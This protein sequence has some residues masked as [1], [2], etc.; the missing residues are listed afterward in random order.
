MA[1]LQEHPAVPTTNTYLWIKTQ[2]DFSAVMRK[3]RAIHGKLMILRYASAPGA[4]T[5]F[6]FV[7][8]KTVGGAVV[9][10]L[11][12]RRM[13]ELARVSEI[14]KPWDLIFIAKAAI[15]TS[16]FEDIKLEFN[17]LLGKAGVLVKH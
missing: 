2:Q 13:R 15:A 8:S 9:R 4:N 7:V 14:D 6:G 16:K 11:A 3:G 5:R 10:N 12:K 1:L 17:S